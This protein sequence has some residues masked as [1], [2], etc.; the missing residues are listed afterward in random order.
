MSRFHIPPEHLR[1]ILD[2]IPDGIGVERE[3][4]IVW[5]NRGFARLYGYADASE[6]LGCTLASFVVEED[7]ARLEDYSARRLH[8]E[9]VP[10]HYQFRGLRRDGEQ[11]EVEIFVSSYRHD[12]AVHVLG[13]LRDVTERV[14]MARR[15]EQGQKLEALGTLTRGIAH[16]FNN[17]LTAV[18]GNIAV[19]RERIAVGQDPHK[20]LIRAATA[21]EKGAQLTRQ[22]QAFTG[23]QH[24]AA[25]AADPGQL[26]RDTVELLEHTITPAIQV[27]TELDDALCSV[28]LPPDQLQ[29]IL[30]NLALNAVDAMEGEGRLTLRAQ[31]AASGDR[32]AFPGAT[33]RAY[34][35]F[36]VEDDGTGIAPAVLP[37]IFEP[38]FTTKPEGQGTGLGLAVVFGTVT[39]HGGHIQVDSAPGE[40]T[41]FTIW[42]P[43]SPKREQSPPRAPAP[44]TRPRGERTLLVVD[45]DP[46]VRAIFQEILELGGYRVLAVERGDDA[47][48]LLGERLR[49]DEPV[50]MALVDLVMP[51]MDGVSCIARLHELAPSLPV[52]LCTGLDKDG[53][54]EQLPDNP[55][56]DVM[57][58]PVSVDRLLA[59]VGEK[60]QAQ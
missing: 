23:R 5:A 45:D 4:R 53:R 32:A 18:M 29:Q 57:C 21:A 51:G 30:M 8:G 56:I 19:A 6:V 50:H 59:A 58:K 13:A 33:G 22:L 24:P 60:L 34:L 15:M 12:G 46:Q 41:R 52:L 42:L 54:L 31:P 39:T 48:A 37:R 9:D 20:A 11:V 43:C 47:V 40:G 28:A 16:D 49:A 35:R 14:A 7:L 2:A 44:A 10:D 27:H 3:G 1:A 25:E 36:E 17:L 38:F 26:V 55:L